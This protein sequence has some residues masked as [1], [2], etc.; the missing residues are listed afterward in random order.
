VQISG[1]NTIKLPS[2]NLQDA[3]SVLARAL[4]D[5][6]MAVFIFP[7]SAERRSLLAGIYMLDI[8]KALLGGEIYTTLS[9]RGVTVWLSRGGLSARDKERIGDIRK[10]L[11]LEM[12][13][14]SSRRLGIC[15]LYIDDLHDH[16]VRG[17]HCY[18]LT[19]GVEPS[20]QGR[21]IGGS[22]LKPMLA[23]ADEN[24]WDCYVETMREK[25]LEFYSR[26]GFTVRGGVQVPAGGPYIWALVRSAARRGIDGPG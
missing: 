21:G 15:E 23:A 1:E 14:G 25:N 6:P 26:H 3:A 17:N 12:G 18:L 13:D 9:L 2:S 8:E 24:G 16:I 11:A 19:L 7:D 22:L 5:D 10:R 20:Q 4:F